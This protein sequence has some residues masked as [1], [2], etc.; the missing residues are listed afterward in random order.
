MNTALSHLEIRVRVLGVWKLGFEDFG[1]G[2]RTRGSWE[3]KRILF[4]D[5]FVGLADLV[6]ALALKICH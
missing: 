1:V 3:N 2:R 4:F 5:S 6:A